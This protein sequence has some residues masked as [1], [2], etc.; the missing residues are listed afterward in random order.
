MRNE[1]PYS[2]VL[3]SA[4]IIPVV[5]ATE[6]FVDPQ[7]R[8][9]FSFFIL[10]SFYLASVRYTLAVCLGVFAHEVALKNERLR[11]NGLWLWLCY[12]TVLVLCSLLVPGAAIFGL[13]VTLIIT[14][15]V[16][17]LSIVQGFLSY[18]SFTDKS[19]LKDIKWRLAVDVLLLAIL[20]NDSVMSDSPNYQTLF[21]VLVLLLIADFAIGDFAKET[22]SEM[23][24]AVKDYFRDSLSE[25]T[26]PESR[27]T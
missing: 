13:V 3:W 16:I 20:F 26:V 2:P 8:E 17:I 22:I 23:V 24:G 19:H 21:L 7:T 9:S 12:F 6:L 4:I 11:K 10:G 27:E 25:P 5:S 18:K 14:A 15:L 1:A